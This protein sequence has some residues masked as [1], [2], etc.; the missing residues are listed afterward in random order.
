M[1][2][3]K[4]N[5]TILG[6]VFLLSAILYLQA[7]EEG[8][9]TATQRLLTSYTTNPT[10]T[11]SVNTF[12]ASLTRTTLTDSSQGSAYALYSNQMKSMFT[13]DGYATL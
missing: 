6:L 4:K 9:V 2:K 1:L 10:R 3:N 12:C 8:I 5:I 13:L 11:T 7:D